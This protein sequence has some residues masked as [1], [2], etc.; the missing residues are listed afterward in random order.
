MQAGL[1]TQAGSA[2]TQAAEAI[3]EPDNLAALRILA[4]ESAAQQ[5]AV[6]AAEHELQ[7]AT[8]ACCW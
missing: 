8:R 5:Q 6:S 4:D 1:A 3:A 7:S 2:V